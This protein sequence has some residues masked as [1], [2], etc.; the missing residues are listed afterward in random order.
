[1]GPAARRS[2]ASIIPGIASRVDAS[3][4]YKQESAD[5]VADHVVKETAAA[6]DIEQLFGVALE[7]R[8]VNGA[9]V[10]GLEIA[11]D[12]GG[13]GERKARS[14]STAANEVKSCSPATSAAACCMAA[15]FSGYGV[16][17]D[18]A[19]KE[20]WNY[21][22][23]PDAVMVALG[24]GGVAGVEAFRHFLDGEDANSGG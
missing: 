22:G 13:F 6:N 10:G 5:E 9:D 4:A 17:G 19:G 1:M 15:S 2:R 7:A 16:V 20:G 21:V 23:A 11:A 14:G 3:L 24:E 8:L 12:A 18:V